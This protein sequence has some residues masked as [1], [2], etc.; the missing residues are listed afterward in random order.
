MPRSRPSTLVEVHVKRSSA[1][2]AGAKNTRGAV[3]YRP[4]RYDAE[5]QPPHTAKRKQPLRESAAKQK[6]SLLIRRCMAEI[7]LPACPPTPKNQLVANGN[8]LTPT[9]PLHQ[10][11]D[12][13]SILA[14]LPEVQ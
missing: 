9:N 11:G 10:I 14:M 3:C 4:I 13:Q 2:S 6:I 12:G 8:D 7:S 5:K 1:A